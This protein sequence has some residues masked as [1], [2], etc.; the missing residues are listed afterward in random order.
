MAIKNPDG[1]EYQVSGCIHQYDSQNLEHDLFNVWDQESIEMGGSPL[2]YYEVFI[3]HSSIDPLYLEARSKVFSPV[4]VILYGYYEPAPQLNMVGV[5]GI[6]GGPDEI[7]FEFN[8]QHV[9]KK[10]G[11][12]PKIG[13][14]I[15]SPHKRE[16]WQIIQLGTEV[17]KLWGELRLQM[18]CH[19]FQESLTT[20]EGKVTEKSPTTYKINDIKDLGSGLNLAGGQPI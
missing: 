6:D 17:Y 18:I 15:F 14:R 5:W 11:K 9:L 7:M 19:K 20:G 1:S 2:Y 10:L 4:P 12:I 3:D 8:Y 13:S 16:N